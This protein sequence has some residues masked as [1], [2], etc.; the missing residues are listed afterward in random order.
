MKQDRG[1]K[2]GGG[3]RKKKKKEKKRRCRSEDPVAQAES[4]AVVRRRAF[5]RPKG[6]RVF[7]PDGEEAEHRVY[8]HVLHR[9][10]HRAAHLV[11]DEQSANF[12]HLTRPHHGPPRAAGGG[13]SRLYHVSPLVYLLLFDHRVLVWLVCSVRS[14]QEARLAQM[15]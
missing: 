14:T 11:Q 6:T 9:A 4:T 8:A 10:L 15:R 2:R 3:V 7:H 12:G 1:F 5:P 13:V